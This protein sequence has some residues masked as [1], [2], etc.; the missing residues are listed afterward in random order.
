[1]FD[2]PFQTPASSQSW[3]PSDRLPIEMQ[4]QAGRR[5]I[6]LDFGVELSQLDC[7]MDQAADFARRAKKTIR[8]RF[9]QINSDA[10]VLPIQVVA[11][12]QAGI[13][14]LYLPVAVSKLVVNPETVLALALRMESAA[15]VL[16]Y[17]KRR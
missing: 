7:S 1:M 6:I 16:S 8:E 13:V 17:G 5:Q 10:E 12:R 3:W 15:S 2:Q 14:M 9:G 11:R 4:V